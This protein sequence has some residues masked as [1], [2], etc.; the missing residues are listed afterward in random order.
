MLRD[1]ADNPLRE[2]AF[3]ACWRADRAPAE[4]QAEL[5]T[6]AA[7][8]AQLAAMQ[9]EADA[10]YRRTE[11]L[12]YDKETW[13]FDKLEA[14]TQEHGAVTQD[15]LQHAKDSLALA[16]A[17]QKDNLEILEG[18]DRMEQAMEAM[19]TVMGKMEIELADLRS[20][21]HPSDEFDLE[22]SISRRPRAASQPE[23]SEG[24]TA[25]PD[26]MEASPAR[27]PA[28]SPA[29][30]PPKRSP[31]PSPYRMLSFLPGHLGR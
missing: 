22:L 14:V 7:R 6:I 11:L 4:P 15:A 20:A 17:S 26:A 13:A 12:I 30:Q 1:C 23:P 2:S 8:H 21:S 25:G 29:R 28:H 3:V 27:N 31:K 5:D 19:A 9:Q 16:E 10:I 24:P 18:M